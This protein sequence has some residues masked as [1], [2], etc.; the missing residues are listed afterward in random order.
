MP[1]NMNN[2]IAT[3]VLRFSIHSN[4]LHSHPEA[5]FFSLFDPLQLHAQVT[6]PEKDKVDQSF[7]QLSFKKHVP[8]KTW[9]CFTFC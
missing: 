2:N 4:H 9:I 6:S 8:Q 1:I 5:V 7:P 3:I